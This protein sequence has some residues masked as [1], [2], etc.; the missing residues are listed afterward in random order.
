[1]TLGSRL[2]LHCGT[3]TVMFLL[4]SFQKYS[5]AIAIPRQL[6][7]F[8]RPW[9]EESKNDFI[10]VRHMESPRLA[11][12]TIIQQKQSDTLLLFQCAVHFAVLQS[13]VRPADWV[14]PASQSLGSFPCTWR[15]G[16]AVLLE[17]GRLAVMSVYYHR[18][19]QYSLL[20]KPLLFLTSV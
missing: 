5:T 15:T 4:P 2:V 12:R 8:F 3:N 10:R 9:L 14:L 18:G 16:Y 13:Q 1:M 7:N 6:K 20:G 19:F 11:Q 17:G